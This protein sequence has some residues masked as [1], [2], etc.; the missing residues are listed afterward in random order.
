[1]LAA[2]VLSCSCDMLD[3]VSLA[4]DAV[5]VAFRTGL[6][7]TEA[8]NRVSAVHESDQ[9]WSIILPDAAAV[10][11]VRKFCEQSVS[12]LIHVLVRIAS[13]DLL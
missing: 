13:T 5:T 3:F 9:N 6:V 1:M 12:Y 7:V 10:D 8:A 2:A 4:V 11:F